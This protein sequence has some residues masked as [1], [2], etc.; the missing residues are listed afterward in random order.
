MRTNEKAGVCRKL[1]S[2]LKRIISA[3]RRQRFACFAIIS[4]VVFVVIMG[5]RLLIWIHNTAVAESF[6]HNAQTIASNMLIAPIFGAVIGVVLAIVNKKILPSY[7]TFIYTETS[8][9]ETASAP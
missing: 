1:L 5:V 9:Q 8:Q 2:L 4:S 7:N 6:Y 3:C